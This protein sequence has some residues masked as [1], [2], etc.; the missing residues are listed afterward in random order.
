MAIEI[1]T[2]P[3]GGHQLGFI[4]R[5]TPWSVLIAILQVLCGVALLLVWAL[6]L[7]Y[8][9]AGQISVWIGFLLVALTR[10]VRP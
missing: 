9:M 1:P 6:V 3:S 4:K 7:L 2:A 10:W 5:L 8:L